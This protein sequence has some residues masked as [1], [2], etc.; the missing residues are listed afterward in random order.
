MN[1]LQ[2]SEIE[3]VDVVVIGGGIAGVSIAEF[4]ARHSNLSIKLL[5]KAP[6]LG[7]LASGK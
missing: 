1:P 5:E 6:Q 4:L 3:Y 7:T 2:V